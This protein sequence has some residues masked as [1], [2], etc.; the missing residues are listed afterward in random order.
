MI[1]KDCQLDAPVTGPESPSVRACR[2]AVRDA[3]ARAGLDVLARPTGSAH[4]VK[5]GLVQRRVLPLQ[6]VDLLVEL[7]FYVS[8]LH[9]ELLQGIDSSLHRF[10]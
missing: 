6:V 5:Q 9:L 8:T 2:P 3:L 10:R 1:G 7:G 4:L